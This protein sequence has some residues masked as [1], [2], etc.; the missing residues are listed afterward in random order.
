MSQNPFNNRDQLKYAENVILNFQKS[1]LPISACLSIL[2]KSTEELVLFETIKLIKNHIVYNWH[3]VTDEEKNFLRQTLLNYVIN[4]Q[5]L[6]ISVRE[7]VLQIISI[8]I[9]RNYI[10]DKG[11]EIMNL[12][13][14]IKRMIYSGNP[15]QQVLS[16]LITISLLQEFANTISS[17]D[18]CLTFEEHFKAKK[19]FEIKDLLSIFELIL[20]S[21]EELIR[22]FNAQDKSH[23]NLMKHF[24]H[25]L[26]I[27]LTWGYVTTIIPRLIKTCETIASV[28]QVNPL[29]LNSNWSEI[30]L[31]EKT[32]E[33]FYFLYYR[34][35]GQMDLQPKA[36]NCL[37]QLS[38]LNGSIFVTNG[39]ESSFKYFSTYLKF[40]L[41]LL[42]K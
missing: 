29:R 16:C 6:A 35:R 34:V 7:K 14:E 31:S 32:M 12:F 39:P 28:N 41:E 33:I 38:T 1:N 5:N 40:Y 22:V 23:L 19:Y 4:K 2:E 17:D 3:G 10:E 27:I 20:S 25:I 42:K 21:V 18:T 15:D 11:V 24:L 9:K 37:I 30:M 13:A 26:E 36:L 8:I